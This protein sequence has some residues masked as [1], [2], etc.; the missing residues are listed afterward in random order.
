MRCPDCGYRNQEDCRFCVACGYEFTGSPPRTSTSAPGDP[1]AGGHSLLHSYSKS[2]EL[3]VAPG[4]S[5]MRGSPPHVSPTSVE[6]PSPPVTPG[7]TSIPPT[8]VYTPKQGLPIFRIIVIITIIG[9]VAYYGVNKIINWIAYNNW[10]CVNVLKEHGDAVDSVA[11]APNGEHF[12]SGCR[13]KIIRIWNISDLTCKNTFKGSPGLVSSVAYSPDGSLLGSG[14]SYYFKFEKP[15][16]R[17][18]QKIFGENRGMALMWNTATGTCIRSFEEYPKVVWDV[19]FSPDGKYF[20]TCA[21]G[22]TKICLYDVNSG[23]R[24]KVLSGH[25]RDVTSISFSPDSSFLVSGSRDN[26]IKVWDVIL[27]ECVRT[28][29]GHTGWVCDVAY[30]PK[31]RYVASAGLADCTN[32]VGLDMQTREAIKIWDVRKGKCKKTLQGH[33]N[34]I[35]TITYSP[36]GNFIASGSEDKDIRIWNVYNGKCVKTLSGHAQPINS[37]AFSPNG[38]LLISSGEDGTIRLWGPK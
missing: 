36:D 31:G 4:D 32:S 7:R 19:T 35:R 3:S 21:E 11:F 30:S 24:M 25:D 27:G 16:R 15:R 8:Y 10:T 6:V 18:G 13:D 29:K 33:N 1:S 34:T 2:D 38:K 20:A 9:V 28:L 22:D 5:Q 26:K 37:I 12:A 23:N 14:C 17:R